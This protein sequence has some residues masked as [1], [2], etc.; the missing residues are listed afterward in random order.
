MR[1]KLILLLIVAI[2]IFTNVIV[3]AQNEENNIGVSKYPD[4]IGYK[5]G[6]INITATALNAGTDDTMYASAISSNGRWTVISSSS[7]GQYVSAGQTGTWNFEARLANSL[8]SSVTDDIC[9]TIKGTLKS[10]SGLTKC[11]SVT[12]DATATPVTTPG[13]EV[14]LTLMGAMAGVYYHKKYYK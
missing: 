8:S 13:F 6:S 12:G 5:E 4:H 1:T 9:V 3:A 14:I 11:I 7:S 10:D 2:T